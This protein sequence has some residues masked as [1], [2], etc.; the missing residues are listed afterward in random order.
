MRN[1]KGKNKKKINRQFWEKKIKK[2][3]LK[4]A[5][6]I[7]PKITEVHLDV[8]QRPQKSLIWMITKY[9]CYII[10]KSTTEKLLFI[11]RNLVDNVHT[12]VYCQCAPTSPRFLFF[13]FLQEVTQGPVPVENTHY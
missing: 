3:K 6:S 4:T 13:E 11:E 9:E 5:K 8:P 2:E 10:P 1:E 12:N 7:H